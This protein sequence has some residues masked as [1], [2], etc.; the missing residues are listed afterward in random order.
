MAG[1]LTLVLVACGTDPGSVSI[2][3]AWDGET[4]PD[5]LWIHGRVMQANPD[6][7]GMGQ[8]ISE[9]ESPQEYVLGMNLSFPDTRNQDNLAI[10]LEARGD[11]SLESRVLYY[12][13]SDTFSLEAG[14]SVTVDVVVAMVETPDVTSLTIEE[15]VG[16]ADC[17]DCYASKETV[18][19]KLE[20]VGA[21]TVEVANDNDFSVC[22]ETFSV[23][24][25]RK[26]APKLIVGSEGWTVEG[27]NLDC[28][29][30]DA[31]DG[32][33]SVYVR[34]FDARGYPSQTIS[35]QTIIDRK[36]PTEGIVDCA[37][38][39][40][41]IN[42]ETTM[43]F[44]V[45]K[46]D[47][48]WVEACEPAL[49]NPADCASIAGG[50][51]PCAAADD[52]YIPVDSWSH[53]NT[54]GCIRLKDDTVAAVQVK[55]RDFAHN[56]TDWVRFEF[57][58]VAELALTWV[59]IPGGTFDMGC[60]PGDTQCNDDEF[61][62]HAVKLSPF[63]MLKTE[64][65]ESQYL[66]VTGVAPSC[67]TKTEGGDDYPVECVV[68]HHANAFCE[69]VGGRLPTE[70]EW[71]YAAR[72]GTTTKYYCG[73]DP[74]CL[75]KIAW[76]NGNSDGHK[77]EVGRRV[78]NAYGLYDML[79]NVHEWTADWHGSDYYG[80][81]HEHDPKGPGT[82]SY[83]VHRGGGFYGGSDVN[84]RVSYRNGAFPS[85]SSGYFLG[86]RCVRSD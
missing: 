37:D 42:L 26:D 20:G 63:D 78:P 25:P 48:M 79:G 44:G 69:K 27:W 52:N 40:W 22:R 3:F 80:V 36:P 83:R 8:I 55:Y 23:D 64:V 21:T 2:T 28:G 14:E 12:G 38:G 85:L 74:A 46:A 7:E 41:L 15:A 60:S 53:Y 34:T 33:R 10:I 49:D 13:I 31:A 45:V 75:Y 17:P 4:P 5:G 77:H 39:K 1:L 18:T 66:A 43:Q 70:A 62:V 19:L 29:L 67:N 57:D 68:W 11:S 56:E 6:S 81:S 30:E 61:P 54:Q 58:N 59:P 71:E 65:T 72:G 51:Q 24:A 82:G 84:L 32:P 47:E 76:G 16:P 73:D 50:L 86:F 9:T 35:G